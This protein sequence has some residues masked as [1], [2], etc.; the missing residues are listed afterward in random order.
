MAS[1]RDYHALRAKAVLKTFIEAE[2]KGLAP[3]FQQPTSDTFPPI[4]VHARDTPIKVGIIGAGMAGLRAA[5]FIQS[6]LPNV[7]YEIIEA[8][9]RYGGRALT[10]PSKPTDFGYFD[11]GPMRYPGNLANASTFD[12]F[13]ELGWVPKVSTELIPY[14]LNSDNQIKEYNNIRIQG[15]VPSG[16][17]FKVSVSGGGNVPDDYANQGWDVWL[18][19]S[20]GEVATKLSTA[21]TEAEIF[22]ILKPIDAWS[23]RAYLEGARDPGQ[24]PDEIPVQLLLG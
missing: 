12:L 2:K 19:K 10:Y 21:T 6:R 7:T 17:V 11:V 5:K 14:H 20:L 3:E 24:T 9:N 4:S 15:T 8:T 22:D 16:D 1:Q 13:A 18:V 23:C